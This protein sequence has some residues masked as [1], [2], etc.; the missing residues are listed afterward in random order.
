MEVFFHGLWDGGNYANMSD[1][2]VRVETLIDAQ[3]NTVRSGGAVHQT[4]DE[5]T[6]PFQ[7]IEIE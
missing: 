6:G 3:K 4:D 1:Q 5:P 2:V 7:R